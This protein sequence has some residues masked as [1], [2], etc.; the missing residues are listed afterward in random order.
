M[1]WKFLFSHI[2]NDSSGENHFPKDE[3]LFSG[4]KR[5]LL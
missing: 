2:I 4:N 1:V 3:F 5:G